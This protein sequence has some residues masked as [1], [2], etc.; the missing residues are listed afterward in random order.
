M[1]I[2]AVQGGVA[3]AGFDAEG[4]GFGEDIFEKL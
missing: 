3:T 1:S 2:H 4:D